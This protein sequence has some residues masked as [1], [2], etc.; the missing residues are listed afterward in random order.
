MD[1]HFKIGIELQHAQ[2][3]AEERHL[4]NARTLVQVLLLLILFEYLHPLN[5]PL[6]SNIMVTVMAGYLCCEL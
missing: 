2:I 5:K 1:T 6:F 4:D 3:L